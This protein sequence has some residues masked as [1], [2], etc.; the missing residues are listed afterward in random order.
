MLTLFRTAKPFRGHRGII[1]LNALK[2]RTLLHP[3]IEIILFGDDEGA[4][5]IC[6]ECG[7]RHEPHVERHESGVKRL[8]IEARGGEDVVARAK[9]VIIEVSFQSLFEGGPLFD[10]VYRILKAQVL[11]T[12]K[13]RSIT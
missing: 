10:D 7:L 11:P 1:Q 8:I 6:T 12:M 3:D 4:A 5:E 2:S 13:I 9:I